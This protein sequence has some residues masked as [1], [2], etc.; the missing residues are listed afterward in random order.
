MTQALELVKNNLNPTMLCEAQMVEKA[1]EIVEKEDKIQSMINKVQVMKQ[2]MQAQTTSLIN[3]C[4]GKMNKQDQTRESPE[5]NDFLD[6][7][8]EKEKNH[9]KSL[10]LERKKAKEETEDVELIPGPVMLKKN[11][12]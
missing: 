9:L 6:H 12:D 2:E 10:A 3:M 8:T 5:H 11:S 1:Y 4:N 7:L